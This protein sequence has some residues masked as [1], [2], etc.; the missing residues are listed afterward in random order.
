MINNFI[1]TIL[2]D[3][4]S[5][6]RKKTISKS[7]NE[8]NEHFLRIPCWGTTHISLKCI[9]LKLIY[10]YYIYYI[11]WAMPFL[12]PIYLCFFSRTCKLVSIDYP[13][14]LLTK[15]YV[16]L[17]RFSQVNNWIYREIPFTQSVFAYFK[18]EEF[19]LPTTKGGIEQNPSI[20][21]C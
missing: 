21:W 18:W 19:P 4:W 7:I 12:L 16:V 14:I 5:S 20:N 6:V 3:F 11:S 13:L 1:D 8:D 15:V 10:T 17:V 9:D 2:S